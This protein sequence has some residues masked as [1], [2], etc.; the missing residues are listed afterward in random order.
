[1]PKYALGIDF[2]TLSGRAVLVDTTT[3]REAATSVFDY[4]HGVIDDVLPATG[5]KLPPDWALQDAADYLQ[6][7]QAIVP[8]CLNQ[9]GVKGSD[10][11][12]IGVDFTACTLIPTDAEGTPLSFNPKFS[13]NP[14]A[15]VKLWKH[16]AAQPEANRINE[17]ATQRGEKWLGRYGGRTSSEWLFAKAW[18]ILD[19]APEIYEAAE[20][21]YDAGDWLVLQLTGQEKRNACAAGYKACWSKE[22]GYPSSDFLRALDPRL[23][24]IVT[25][26]LAPEVYPLAAKAGGLTPQMAEK[27]GL[28]A[29]TPVAVAAID[30]HV[31]VP[32]CTI[33]KPGTMVMIMGT[34]TCHM[35]LGDEPR[36]FEG[37]A[38]YVADGIVPGF[39]GFEAGQSCVGDHFAWFVENCVPAEYQQ[40][41]A[42]KGI[43]IH[44]LLSEKASH[45]A[46]GQ[47]GLLA[48][49]WWNGNRSVLMD[50]D[51][52][53]LVLG[54]TLNTRPEEIYR[55]L[56]EAT[57]FGTLVI[58][59][60]F[61]NGGVPVDEIVACGGLAE[62]NPVLMQ[63]YSDITGR[64][65][66]LAASGQAVAL[67]SA[68][69]GAVAA[70][71]LAGG[72][73]SID[74]AAAAMARLKEERYKPNPEN[75]AI[76]QKL[77]AE[78]KKLHDY[79]GRGENDVMKT[80]KELRK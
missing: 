21:L 22:D 70:G 27:L 77:Y 29:G 26:K 2:G 46:P 24:T 20:K 48:L 23:E 25:E 53:G 58:I 13:R 14:H 50:A 4:P 76:Y 57:A 75:H 51:L 36:E 64:E 68:I 74:E 38:G 16:H 35:A 56:V 60:T 69:F 67:G 78:Y 43:S 9:A 18:Q 40:E 12:G 39:Y 72:Y 45:L 7:L 80:L 52:T 66:K 34:S 6:T 33:T 49:D 63:I 19:E 5:Q 61:V 65:F 54:C 37:L 1:M 28:Q 11:I 17:L 73:D 30:A 3:G 8:D 47:S 79:F 44:N 55:A 41:A 10:V 59:E 62:R 32:A 15:Y 71:S 31:A 42:E